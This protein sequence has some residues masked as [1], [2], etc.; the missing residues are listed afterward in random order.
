MSSVDNNAHRTPGRSRPSDISTSQFTGNHWSRLTIPRG[1]WQPAAERRH[2]RS[3]WWKRTGWSLSEVGYGMW[4]M[5]GWT[6]SND[7]E[8]AAAL[9]RAASLGCNFFD[10]AWAYGEGRS[11]RLLGALLRRHPQRRL[12]AGTKVPPKNMR[13]PGRASTP[14]DE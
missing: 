2:V 14:V 12:Y 9:D 4:G 13:W 3:R 5:G 1:R 11:E 7:Q 8:S 10:T 6:G